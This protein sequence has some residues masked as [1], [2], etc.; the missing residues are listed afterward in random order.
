MV[1]ARKTP[2]QQD[3]GG[4]RGLILNVGERSLTRLGSSWQPRGFRCRVTWRRPLWQ[5]AS[6]VSFKSSA[7]LPVSSRTADRSANRQSNRPPLPR[8]EGFG[9]MV[10]FSVCILYDPLPAWDQGLPKISW[11]RLVARQ[12]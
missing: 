12:R 10:P 8:R 6:I 7:F 3:P 2:D 5:A 1:C 9:L 4:A 11:A